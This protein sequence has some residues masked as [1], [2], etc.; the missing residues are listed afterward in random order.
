MFIKFKYA[1]LG[2]KKQ[3]FKIA[4]FFIKKSPCFGSLVRTISGFY[5][6]S[7]QFFFT[8]WSKKIESVSSQNLDFSSQK[9]HCYA[10]SE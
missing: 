1:T 8:N 10:I 6:E 4:L 7:S 5:I 9:Y 3:D 2:K